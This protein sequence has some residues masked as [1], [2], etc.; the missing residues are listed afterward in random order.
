M[1][2][3]Y[4]RGIPAR[5]SPAGGGPGWPALLAVLA[6]AL[7]FVV[8]VL[9]AHRFW[10]RRRRRKMAGPGLLFDGRGCMSACMTDRWYDLAA[11]YY[12][13]TASERVY[14]GWRRAWWR[15]HHRGPVIVVQAE[16]VERRRP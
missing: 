2:G 6:V 15:R 12:E 16:D 11:R 7:G 5:S 1:G 13:A 3:W 4:V 10:V 14:P 8:L 9:A